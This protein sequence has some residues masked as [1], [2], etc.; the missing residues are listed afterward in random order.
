MADR[1]PLVEFQR[2]LARR[3]QNTPAAPT[4]ASL[5][6]VVA[7]PDRL[8][9]EL[10]ELSAVVP[11]PALIPTPHPEPWFRGLAYLRGSF[12]GVVDLAAIYGDG[13]TPL[14][15]ESRILLTRTETQA[16][17][18]LLVSRILG[19]KR[20]EEI[21]ELD[22]ASPPATFSDAGRA[23]WRKLDLVRLARDVDLSRAK[24]GGEHAKSHNSS[25]V[26][27]PQTAS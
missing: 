13:I 10:C 4:G 20:P 23:R 14:S 19:L 6:A 26:P 1:I 7:G 18:G 3:L 12:Y 15:R 21:A 16:P 24:T 9:C 17:F 8:L 5:L 27:V 2:R 25:Q 11:V 22:D